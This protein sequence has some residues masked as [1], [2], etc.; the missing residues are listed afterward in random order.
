M[1]EPKRFERMCGNCSYFERLAKKVKEGIC[2]FQK[3][4]RDNYY[5][6][7]GENCWLEITSDDSC[8]HW[9]FDRKVKKK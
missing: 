6:N 3:K 9:N 2:L 5:T 7:E 8:H 4:R 1:V